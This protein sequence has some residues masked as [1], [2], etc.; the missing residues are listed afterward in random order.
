MNK[1]FFRFSKKFSIII[2]KKKQK[3][4]NLSS[5][6]SLRARVRR[7]ALIPPSYDTAESSPRKF[8]LNHTRSRVRRFKK[9]KP[10]RS[11][12]GTELLRGF[13][14]TPSIIIV[15]YSSIIIGTSKDG[16]TNML[17]TPGLKGAI[18]L[19]RI[20]DAVRGRYQHFF[21]EGGIGHANI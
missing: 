19:N 1:E 3:R 10:R 7:H 13:R 20:K 15:V 21:P 4:Q 6:I 12:R 18:I 8:S 14:R 16:L 11:Y 9:K 2:N 5:P 17:S